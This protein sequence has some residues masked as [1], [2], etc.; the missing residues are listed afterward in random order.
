VKRPRAPGAPA[1]P[2]CSAPSLGFRPAAPGPCRPS[3]S[4]G[5]EWPCCPRGPQHLAQPNRSHQAPGGGPSVWET[6]LESDRM[7]SPRRNQRVPQRHHTPARSKGPPSFRAIAIAAGIFP[8]R[9]PGPPVITVHHKGRPGNAPPSA[10]PCA[11][12]FSQFRPARSG[13]ENPPP[14]GPIQGWRDLV[15]TFHSIG[16]G[17]F[18]ACVRAQP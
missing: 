17:P 7:S 3:S 11:P 2:L 6:I 9:P 16:R 15:S 8:R 18:Q 1:A 10:G 12:P 4:D 5:P 14:S 13:N